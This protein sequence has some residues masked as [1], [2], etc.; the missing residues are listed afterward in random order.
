MR[1][2]LVC[3]TVASAL[4]AVAAYADPATCRRI[5]LDASEKSL[6]TPNH[7]FTSTTGPGLVHKSEIINVGNKSYVKVDAKAGKTA[8]GDD[9][10]A[11]ARI[12]P[13]EAAKK[14]IEAM[15]DAAKETKNYQCAHLRDEMVDGVAA[16]VYSEHAE[17]DYGKSDGQYWISKAQGL[18][19]KYESNSN[20]MTISYRY[21]YTDIQPPANAKGP[22]Q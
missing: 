16:A 3:A 19:V 15:H 12:S 22:D 8:I 18:I 5:I 2:L 11:I 17:T 13:Q 1:G 4:A 6:G 20:D 9:Q 14:T 21:V 7:I 10:W